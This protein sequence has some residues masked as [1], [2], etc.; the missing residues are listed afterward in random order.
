MTPMMQ[1]PVHST[2]ASPRHFGS[3]AL[4]LLLLRE[5]CVHDPGTSQHDHSNPDTFRLE[6]A[7]IGVY[8]HRCEHLN[9]HAVKFNTDFIEGE[10]IEESIRLNNDGWTTVHDI[11]RA[12][13]LIDAWMVDWRCDCTD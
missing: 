12:Y 13:W 11:D 10:A 8:V 5:R 6:Y 2:A 7:L 4:D 3:G 1:P 9:D